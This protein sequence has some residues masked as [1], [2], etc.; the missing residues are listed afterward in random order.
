MQVLLFVLVVITHT[1]D[2]QQRRDTPV[3]RIGRFNRII[4]PLQQG[5]TAPIVHAG[6]DMTITLPTS[7]V[8]L[9]GSATDKDENI[10]T[11]RWR[12][13]DGP[14]DARILSVNTP[15]TNVTNL[16]AGVYRFILSVEDRLE[17]VGRD[18][19]TIT[20]IQAPL[21]PTVNAGPDQTITLPVNKVI[22]NGSGSDPR[23]FPLIFRWTKYIGP[24]NPVFTH[25]TTPQTT[26]ENL[27]EGVYQFILAGFNNRK[28]QA[29]DTVRI[30]VNPQKN[31]PPRADAGAGK[32]ITLPLNT[33]TLNGR[34]SSDPDGDT[35]TFRW[36]KLSGPGNI[37]IVPL[38]NAITR[39][40]NLDQGVYRFLLT[41]ADGRGGV[42]TASTT[43]TVNTPIPVPKSPIADAGPDQEI[44]ANDTITLTGSGT[45]EDGHIVA[46]EWKKIAGPPPYHIVSTTTP[47]TQVY[48]LQAGGYTFQLTVTDNDG[49][50]ATDSM[51]LKVLAV[52]TTDTAATDTI[53]IL[54]PPPVPLSEDKTPAWVSITA[55]IL[56]L[57]G[58]TFTGYYFWW[59]R[60]R[61]KL[62]VY[63]MNPE[64]EALAH[65]MMP[66]H[67]KTEGFI[68]GN[69]T[70][71]NIR[72]MEKKGLAFRVLNTSTLTVN[73]P[74]VTRTYQYSFKKG[75][76]Q[77]QSVS[78]DF[79]GHNYINILRSPEALP[80]SPATLPAFYLI[81]LDGPLLDVF[82]KALE[83][84]GISIVQRIP[85]DSYIIY[86]TNSEQLDQLHNNEVF[87]F[88]RIINEYTAEDTG[89][90]IRK[91]RYVNTFQAGPDAAFTIDLVLH[92][93]EDAGIVKDF[94]GMNRIERID[95]Y[96]NIIRIS[97]RPHTDLPMLLASNKYIQ[98]IYEHIPK[99]WYNDIARQMIGIDAKENNHHTVFT[100]TGKGQVIAVADTG[101]DANH[102]DL[103]NNDLQAAA[104][105]RPG[106]TSDPH[107]HGTHV[108]GTILGDG[109]ASH[110]AI[111]GIAPGATLFFQ[112]LL[113]DKDQLVEL[114]LRLPDLLQQA[115]DNKARIL[116][117]SWGGPTEAYYT[118][119]STMVDE[120]VFDHPEMLV[121]VSAGNESKEKKDEQGNDITATETV[122]SP[123]TNKNGLTVGANNSI[124]KKDDPESMAWFSSKGPCIP[125]SRIKPDITAPGTHILSTR[126]AQ[127]PDSNFENFYDNDAYIFL[128]GTSMATPV[129]SGAAAL[130]REYYMNREYDT[131]SAALI[132]ATLLNGTH[133]LTGANA[134]L[135]STMIPNNNQGFGMLYLPDSIPNEGSRFQLWFRD[136]YKDP[137]M[138]MH[139]G[140][141]R[142]M[143]QLQL[144]AKSW[145]RVCLVYID[146]PAVGL[147]NNLDLIM[148]QEGTIQ[149]WT[150]N[151]GIN[152]NEPGHSP[153]KEDFRNNIEIIRIAEAES[154]HYNINIVATNLVR[155]IDCV[156][157]LVVTTGDM[158]SSLTNIEP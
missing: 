59:R 87:R 5:N 38:D 154:G 120:F 32:T 65:E 6:P 62:I 71:G 77:L 12:V 21:P 92:R 131:P 136:A 31:Q 22:L 133:R 145:V 158:D 103:Q 63:F 124:R 36:R 67:H 42:D 30:T 104:W 109:S 14:E 18:T 152:A 83:E 75:A 82:S 46:Y 110:G 111:K 44:H 48:G 134:M 140:G 156:Y 114:D 100:E 1:A 64:E 25:Q 10:R 58:A 142:R 27:Q 70:R 50:Q 117:L 4:R 119:D 52:A 98:A 115:Y 26:V 2:A 138:I 108:A 7:S 121:V 150:G 35:L 16:R 107:G 141:E 51:R 29:R 118:P 54:P 89:F 76:P 153:K 45:D 91:D 69:T 37:T 33:T 13:L 9:N 99:V 81:T 55:G 57:G 72:E 135:G 139:K 17:K 112:S 80:Y 43:V 11:Y 23:G 125:E 88:I 151:A 97:M 102:P 53:K 148:E 8:M 105:G 122:G 129:V 149:K 116:N 106:D 66:G 127:A 61:K 60:Q 56:A 132:K 24:G 155:K 3:R 15:Q 34:N 123:G 143:F 19:V 79:P 86:V 96:R 47:K 28:Q 144:K 85:E 20:V 84:I 126:S 90:I 41:V 146:N 93:E 78:R 95:E 49:L 157:A 128:S 73:T 101:V 68:I 137:A 39:I 147:Q 40:S 130:V 113:D 74:G 94:L